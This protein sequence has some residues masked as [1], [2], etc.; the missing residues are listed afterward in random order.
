MF[1]TGLFGIALNQ[2][3]LSALQYIN[4]SAN[5]NVYTMEYSAIKSNK[6]IHGTSW[7]GSSGKYVEWKPIP[8][9]YIPYDSIFITFSKVQNYK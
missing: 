1:L 5:W 8:R 6:L 2:K 3:Q 4:C 7:D 9:G